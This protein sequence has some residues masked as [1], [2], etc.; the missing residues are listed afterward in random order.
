MLRK[1][2]YKKKLFIYYFS[3]FFVFSA[4]FILYQYNREKQFK[5]V[6][7]ESELHSMSVLTH[8]FIKQNNILNNKQYELIDSV[9]PIVPFPDTRLTVI[10]KKGKVLYDSFVHDYDD[11]ENHLQRPEIQKAKY[12]ENG[13]GS[14]IRYSKTTGQEFYYYAHYYNDHY[15]RAAVVFDSRVKDFLKAER[16][17]LFFIAFIF[18]VMW[19]ILN[20]VTNRMS[21]SITK[22]K[23]FAVNLRQNKPLVEDIHFPQNELGVISKQI[24]SMYKK[25][26]QTKD[27]LSLEKEKLIKHLFVLNEGVAFFS[28]DKKAVLT[29]SH[30]VQYINLIAEKSSIH[31][32]H[33][34]EVKDFKE[35]QKFIK[36]HVDKDKGEISQND[37]PQLQFSIRK[38]G[39]YYEVRCIVFQDKSF[40]VFIHD[41]TKLEKRRILKQQMTSNIA[42]ELKTP[43]ASVLGYLET[44]LNNP[45][46]EQD[47]KNYFIEKAYQQS[48]RLTN[49][50]EDIVVLNKI[51]EA[52]EY[53]EF[54]SL[55]V[56]EV[57]Q[58]V[59]ENRDALILQQNAE[60][61]INVKPNVKIKGNQS[62]I[63]SIFQN[64][65]DN[66]LSYAGANVKISID[67]YHQDEE[68]CYFSVIDNGVGIPKEH[69]SRIFERFYRVDSGRSRKMG[70]TGLGLAIVKHAVQIHNGEVS[71][72]N[73]PE[74]GAQFYF[75]LP[76]YTE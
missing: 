12:N 56:K 53:Y 63:M 51:E 16:L 26:E 17:F 4:S 33:L 61:K 5:I 55:D 43:V 45:E 36:K 25:L 34:F 39:N 30:F 29:N 7:L 41:I 8:N 57:I 75:T 67:M 1:F 15:V 2:N 40:E 18:V 47:K 14:N 20:F 28:K 71:V 22:L 58:E 13:I 6:Q 68:F 31:P 9:I 49:L 62:L 72:K 76:K 59:V 3:V 70:G 46:I 44:I 65:I 42:H 66:S 35:L 27:A 23:D 24:V 52:G 19:F 64:L 69:L 38:G 10:D 54:G 50:I 60:V 32:E 73:G 74:G 11:M 21:E 48:I 37:M